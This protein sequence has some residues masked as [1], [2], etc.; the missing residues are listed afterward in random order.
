LFE[1]AG[2]DSEDNGYRHDEKE[3]GQ[4]ERRLSRPDLA[5]R[6]TDLRL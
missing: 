3:P 6:L 5:N 4:S 1:A 2:T